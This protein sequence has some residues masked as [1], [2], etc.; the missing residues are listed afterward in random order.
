MSTFRRR[1]FFFACLLLPGALIA[2][3]AN[4]SGSSVRPQTPKPAAD[5]VGGP[6]PGVV[7][8]P[9]G[10]GE[11]G[12]ARHGVGTEVTQVPVTPSGLFDTIPRSIDRRTRIGDVQPRLPWSS[13]LIGPS[14]AA[15][16]REIANTD[17]RAG[18]RGV[19]R[20]NRARPDLATR[21]E[22]SAYTPKQSVAVATDTAN[23]LR[24]CLN[25]REAK[26]ATLRS[27]PGKGA[28]NDAKGGT[29]AA[30]LSRGGDVECSESLVE[31]FSPLAA[32][33]DAD[34]SVE[35]PELRTA[36]SKTFQNPEGTRTVRMYAD[37]VHEVGSSGA[38]IDVDP[39]VRS[40]TAGLTAKSIGGM[41][42][43]SPVGNDDRSVVEVIVPKG[44]VGYR[45][46]G[47]AR[48][49]AF[50][51]ANTVSYP[52]IFPG[53]T[54]LLEQRATGLKGGFLLQRP[55]TQTTF[56]LPLALSKGITPKLSATGGID[57]V[58]DSSR[59]RVAE[60]P[61]PV[62]TDYLSVVGREP[63]VTYGLEKS[64]SG[65]VAVVIVEP[66][67]LRDPARKFPV[68]VDPAITNYGGVNSTAGMSDTFVAQAAPTSNF[69]NVPVGWFWGGA[70][71]IMKV[72]NYGG[73]P[74]RGLVKYD[75][76]PFA[77]RAII[78]A[79]W[80]PAVAESYWPNY[81]L[82]VQPALSPW[83]ASTVTWNSQPAVDPNISSSTTVY[84][85]G[86]TGGVDILPIAK[87]WANGSLAN[88]G[89]SVKYVDSSTNTVEQSTAFADLFTMET[90]SWGSQLEVTYEWASAPAQA[91]PV[92]PVTLPIG[93]LSTKPL[94]INY[95]QPVLNTWW[96]SGAYYYWFEV[97]TSP[98]FSSSVWN[99]G[100]ANAITAQVPAGVLQ[101]GGVYWWRV[102]TRAQ[103]ETG[104]VEG[105]AT[106]FKIDLRLG[107]DGKSAYDSH[108]GLAVNLSNGNLATSVKTRSVA[109][110]GGSTAISFTYNSQQPTVSGLSGSY[111]DG[112][113][114]SGQARFVRKDPN[115]A[116]GYSG[117]S[118]GGG[119]FPQLFSVRW[120][121]RIRVPTTGTYQFGLSS[122][123]GSEVF[124]AS[125]QAAWLM[126]STTMQ[127]PAYGPGIALNSTSSYPVSL[128]YVNDDW[129]WGV[130]LWVRDP[131]GATFIVPSSW[132]VPGNDVLPQGWTMS[133]G[134]TGVAYGGLRQDG[135]S[136]TI[137]DST[138]GSISFL[139][140]DQTPSG[141]VALG[142]DPSLVLSVV[143]GAYT[144]QAG[145]ATYTFDAS[146]NVTDVRTVH[147]IAKRGSLQYTYGGTPARLWSVVDPVANRTLVQL[148]YAG[149]TNPNTLGCTAPVGPGVTPVNGSLC[150]LRWVD[151]H[152]TR[153]IYYGSGQIAYISEYPGTALDY[154]AVI[155]G[156]S[157]DANGRMATYYA[158]EIEE[159]YV[160]SVG[161]ATLGEGIDVVYDGS[162]RVSSITLPRA[163]AGATRIAHTYIYNGGG[164]FTATGVTG[165][166]A[167]SGTARYVN[168]DGAGR[169]VT[170][171]DANNLVTTYVWDTGGKDQLLST[172]DPAGRRTTSIYDA[173]DRVTDTYGPA[174]SSCYPTGSLVPSNCPAAP[175]SSK[176]FDGG[177][178]GLAAAYYSGQV[179]TG[180]PTYQSLL[181]SVQPNWGTAS[182]GG[183]TPVDFAARFTGIIDVPSSGQYSF[184][185]V[186]DNGVRLW[187]DDQ[188]IIDS[189]GLASGTSEPGLYIGTAGKH[190]IKIEY[191]DTG[192]AASFSLSWKTPSA[193]STFVAVPAA[194]LQPGFDLVT[195]ETTDDATAGSPGSVVATSYGTEPWL[196]LAQ[197][198]RVDP[199]GLNLKTD[200]FYD[201]ANWYRLTSKTMPGGNQWTYQY[202]GAADVSAPCA[203]M[204]SAPQAGMLK[205]K[206]HPGGIR[207]DDFHYDTMGRIA[208][209]Q[210]TGRGKTCQY[211][212]S[213]DRLYATDQY[214]ASQVLT[215]LLRNY[216][217]Y[218]NNPLYEYQIEWN[219]A[220]TVILSEYWSNLDFMKRPT[221]T[222]RVTQ[223]NVSTNFTYDTAGRVA[224]EATF[225]P[226][227]QNT[228]VNSY[229][230][231]GRLS[232]LQVFDAANV[233]VAG[234]I[235]QY[236]STGDL[237]GV[238]Y[239][240]ATKLTVGYDSLLRQNK[241]TW[242]TSAN[243]LIASDEVTRSQS[244]RIVDQLIDGV[245]ANA[246]GP[247]FVYDGAGRLVDSYAQAGMRVQF[248]F[249]AAQTLCAGGSVNAGKNG[250]RAIVTVN[251]VVRDSY[252]YDGGDR[253]ISTNNGIQ[254]V[255]YDST[256]NATGWFGKTLGFD[257]ANRHVSTGAT[258]L[259]R[260]LA[261]RVTER[262][263][264]GVVTRYYAMP[265]SGVVSY[266]ADGGTTVTERTVG[267]VGGVVV[268]VGAAGQT[269][270]YPNVHGDV[271]ATANG[272]GVKQG[273]TLKWDPDGKA[274]TSQPNLLRGNFEFGWVGRH[275]KLVDVSDPLQPLVE[276][277]AR[278]YSPVHARFLSVDPVEGG[279]A[280][281]YSYPSDPVNGFDLT[282]LFKYSL[283]YDLGESDMSPEELF[284]YWSEN[285]DAMFPI[286]G[287]PD[288]LPGNGKNIDLNVAKLPF[289]VTVSRVTKT[290]FRLDT[291]L[292]H[293]DHK[294]W[295]EFNIERGA[296]G[297]LVLKIH[298]SVSDASLASLGTGF[299]FRKRAYRAVA[300]RTWKPLANN[301]ARA[302]G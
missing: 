247:N 97:G 178:T 226:G 77:N 87:L 154:N 91:V 201:A 8:T 16:T 92:S 255:F 116:F 160:A 196:G 190:R 6:P 261:D 212:D 69:D 264:G 136:V 128:N 211:Y 213:K 159:Q 138:G 232:N 185:F 221:G 294:G 252:C 5:P 4:S 130:E 10:S 148:Q 131:G 287:A 113:T 55:G 273:L 32:D 78:S 3:S 68:F 106:S 2:G 177:I 248:G 188:L 98:Q 82:K 214:D 34:L 96:T 235:P 18:S 286:D 44:S 101:N 115:V 175:H 282:G 84:S 278:V 272:L 85:T 168:F 40:D 13:G 268:T 123:D 107:A 61:A 288:T 66:S 80:K 244:G 163:A 236:G 119:L 104:W 17:S 103:F 206:V 100:W 109:A 276:M 122:D 199:N 102:W 259:Q 1:L 135:S 50:V 239:T 42:R 291:R 219:P 26:G 299:L 21:D 253:L 198:V 9:G 22:L 71:P 63:V 121:G 181:T 56:R 242:A 203:S 147:D 300:S 57:F 271:L 222:A 81:N 284:G 94:T 164:G 59:A 127:A 7:V 225:T 179:P 208:A 110:L 191:V 75:V 292:G 233:L 95:T 158:P 277:G 302:A 51:S 76:S 250:N 215:R 28:S 108:G 251:G 120:S 118:P 144:L 256:G 297:H 245:D 146:G 126:N 229:D 207:N 41:S 29:P 180:A 79:S 19:G 83:T 274:L 210:V 64:T 265:G 280:N 173:F 227:L 269:W 134:E 194:S 197:S 150:Q 224:T 176:V 151:G 204:A 49:S 149:G 62:V 114:W 48:S 141:F 258:T 161:V 202:W 230:N 90:A 133:T 45:V 47:A 153:V 187:V 74:A 99:S 125:T 58:D 234:S 12:V 137:T 209:T 11:P 169:R 275:Q 24:R 53:V 36:S 182:P 195:T 254:Q 43:F 301:L 117:N 241:L 262:S 295:I 298:A 139:R 33:A 220:M 270:S 186:Q 27:P 46:E 20:V 249:G 142:G 54:L 143:N 260:D 145:D 267:L 184:Q 240:N 70:Q 162:G 35:L 183:A 296:N 281:D 14:G 266:V 111:Y 52:D 15:V 112:T 192:G 167:L 285:F 165:N 171:T 243:G 193:P 129:G 170:D 89:L 31:T 25:D 257:V 231:G 93:S 152:D 228:I 216:F 290:G 124:V 60:M 166:A 217:S 23:A 238:T 39:T 246:V 237:A 293:P 140:S 88:N 289:P 218:A 86:W 189:W 30:A 67:W 172:T 205:R 279:N 38:W 73:L 156:Y 157:Y 174:P 263:E 223:A 283:K 72:G 105:P 65:W 200:Y 132:F 37:Q 155:N